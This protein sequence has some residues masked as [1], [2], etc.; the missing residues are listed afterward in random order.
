MACFEAAAADGA[1][2]VPEVDLVRMIAATLD[3]PLPPAIASAA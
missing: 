3:C 2:Q 1:F